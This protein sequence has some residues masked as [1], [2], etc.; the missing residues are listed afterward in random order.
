MVPT[1]CLKQILVTL[2]NS[3]PTFYVGTGTHALRFPLFACHSPLLLPQRPSAC[4]HSASD[5]KFLRFDPLVWTVTKFDS[6]NMLK[7]LRN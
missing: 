5:T 6:S 2:A 7:V 1:L 3:T 4:S